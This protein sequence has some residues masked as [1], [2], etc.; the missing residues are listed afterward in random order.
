MRERDKQREEIKEKRIHYPKN[1][2]KERQKKL[3]QCEREREEKIINLLS[4]KER[5]RRNL[6]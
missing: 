4:E 6:R 1:T 5:D 3:R 2:L